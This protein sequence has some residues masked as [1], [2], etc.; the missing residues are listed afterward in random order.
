MVQYSTVQ[1]SIGYLKKD[2]GT[3]QSGQL[4]FFR[5]TG[6]KLIVRL[7]RHGRRH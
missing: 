2:R 4:R 5:P 7:A 6:L 1:Y 3:C